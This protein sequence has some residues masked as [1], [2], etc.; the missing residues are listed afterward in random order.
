[1]V[2]RADPLAHTLTQAFAD[3]AQA[4]GI[5]VDAASVRSPR[6]KGRVES[7]VACMRESWFD[8]EEFADLERARA[9]ARQWSREVAGARIHGTTRAV[10][11]EVF[12]REERPTLRA[13]PEAS[14]DVPH[15]A[16]AKVHPD[17]HVQVLRSLYSVPTRL[18]GKTVRVRADSKT[19]RIY[20]G[21]EIIKTHPRMAPGKRSTD[22]SDYPKGTAE[23]AMRSVD[24]L[25]ARAR[26]RGE[27]I[28]EVAARLLGGPL[29]WTTMRQGYELLRLCDRFGDARLD[30]L[31]RRA[32]D[33]DVIDV[34]RM[35][36]MLRLAIEGEAQASD[37]GKLHA[38]PMPPRFAREDA[39]FTTRGGKPTGGA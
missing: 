32:L 1:M 26:A 5:F 27:N 39:S 22:S 25:R 29:P 6:D 18:I 10:P 19:V 28:G 4:R 16:D 17:H 35:G 24:A 20:L 30:A 33:F 37:E 15:W 3:Y 38:L 9:S 2:G 13:A 7:Q 34:P 21:T 23:Y 36:R 31:C 11:R 14:Y 8:G 12:E